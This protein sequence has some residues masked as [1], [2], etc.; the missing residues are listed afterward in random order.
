[1][2]IKFCDFEAYF[3]TLDMKAIGQAMKIQG[4]CNVYGTKTR[5]RRLRKPLRSTVC[6]GHWWLMPIM[7]ATQEAEIRRTAV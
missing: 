5:D 2:Q 1:M 4:T 6:V 7:L 3:Y